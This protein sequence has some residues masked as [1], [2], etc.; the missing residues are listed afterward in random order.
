MGPDSTSGWIV[1]L[2]LLLSLLWLPPFSELAHAAPPEGE[3][4]IKRGAW[5]I[6]PGPERVELIE[7]GLETE[8]LWR[9]YFRLSPGM[10]I[11]VHEPKSCQTSQGGTP[12]L[13]ESSVRT[14][15]SGQKRFTA[16]V[17]QMSAAA[18][19]DLEVRVPWKAWDPLESG[20]FGAFGV[21][22]P[23]LD[24]AC[25]GERISPAIRE[26]IPRM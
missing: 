18:G 17:L 3:C 8:N 4:L 1:K 14:I 20:F 11:E 2:L 16:Y 26:R 25:M 7:T 22:R 23:C 9:M 24:A 5:C 6:A 12:A 10:F 15:R 19:C 13:K 21:I